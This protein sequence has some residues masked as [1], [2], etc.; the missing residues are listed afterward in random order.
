MLFKFDSNQDF[1]LDAIQSVVDLFEGQPRLD[2]RSTFALGK[3]FASIGNRLDLEESALFSNLGGVQERNEIALDSALEF[4]E[5]SIQTSEGERTARFVNFSVEMETGTGKTYVYIRTALELFAR[6]GFRKFIIVVPSVAIREG[7]LKDLSITESHFG[8]LY[9][10][11]PYHSYAYDSSNLSQVR[12]FALSDSVEFMIMTIDSFNKASNVLRQTTDRLQGETPIHLI[13]ETNPILILD[14]PQNMESELAVK[15]LSL[16]NPLCALRYSATHRNPYNLTYRLTPF[17]AYREGLVK[18]IE[19]ASVLREDDVGQPFIRVDRID[20]TKKS[21]SA[22]L[23]IHKL[24]RS[25]TVREGRITVKPG[26]SLEA[27]TGRGEYEGYEVDEIS[28]GGEFVRFSNNVEVRTGEA[29]GAE[30]EAIFEAQI[31]YTIEEHFR[32]QRRL[33]GQDIKVLSLFFIDRVANYIDE[34]VI[35]RLFDRVFDELKTEYEEWQDR[36][37]ASVQAAYFAQKRRKGGDVEVLDSSSGESREDEAAYDLIM[38]DKERLLS[39]DE[40]VAFIFSHSALREGWDN[41]NVFQICTLN[42]TASEI[43]KRQEVGRGVRLAR[44][45]E[46]SRVHDERV[47]VLTVVANESYERYV[48]QLQSE[49][50]DEYGEDGLPPKPPNAR[51]RGMAR[52]RKECVLKPEFKELWGRISQR[53]RYSLAI[54]SSKVIEEV[55]GRLADI[56]VRPPRVAVM[57]AEV[58][59]GADNLLEALQMSAAKTAVDLVGRYPLPNLVELMEDQLANTTPPIRLT[60]GTLLEIFKRCTVQPEALENPQEFATEA[61]RI[62]KDVLKDHLVEGIKYERVNDWYEMHLLEGEIESWEQYLV[63]ASRSVYDHVVFDSQIERS[64]VEGLESREDVKIYLKLPKWF[65]VPTPVGD[66]NPDWAIVMEERD[67]HGKPTGRD[68]LY[69][70]RETKGEKWKTELRPNERRKIECGERHFEDSL[71][72]NFKVVSSAKELP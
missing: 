6:Y 25:G 34:G 5:S 58:K 61:V 47:N 16:L 52:L 68:L 1:Q 30:R 27:K 67:A 14:E 44:D 20:A 57:K 41:P 7:V 33:R 60:R 62:I 10:N 43:K 63:P 29:F 12:Q 50:S 46:G 8:Q 49:I 48:T 2:A 45:Q 21:V 24:M 42:Q 18:R 11:T 36:A 22:R 56:D 70:V 4:I 71:G 26:D 55:I 9:G 53:T 66:Y 51:K 35:R 19:V 31:R 40:P 72:V 39:F 54:D 64:F 37:P 69:L 3:G 23:T 65:K 13:Q 32:K 28:A 59:V 15:S 38:R 17:D